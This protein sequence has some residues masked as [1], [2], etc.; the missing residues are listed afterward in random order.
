MLKKHFTATVPFRSIGRMR[1]KSMQY[2]RIGDQEKITN[3]RKSGLLEAVGFSCFLPGKL[4]F[5][6][7]IQPGIASYLMCVLYEAYKYL[8]IPTPALPDLSGRHPPWFLSKK[9][10]GLLLKSSG[11]FIKKVVGHLLTIRCYLLKSVGAIC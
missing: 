2:M 9:C 3:E 1:L 11:P 10:R 6:P 5:N 4:A 8:G 7:V